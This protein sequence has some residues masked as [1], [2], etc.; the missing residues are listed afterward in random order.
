MS[1]S[2]AVIGLNMLTLW[3][4]RGTLEPWLGPLRELLAAGTVQPVIAE[5]F[6]FEDAGAAHSMIVERRNLGKVLLV[7]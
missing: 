5:A 2:K 1:E 4:E 3:K 7:P 6:G